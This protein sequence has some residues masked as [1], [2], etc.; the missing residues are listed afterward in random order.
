MGMAKKILTGK[1]WQT[2]FLRNR[3]YFLFVVGLFVILISVKYTTNKELMK[4][5]ALSKEVNDLKEEY[6]QK[7]TYYQNSVSMTAIEQRLESIGVG[8]SK[9]P[10]KDIIIIK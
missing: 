4:I 3:F 5:N 2:V 9:E 6:L 1:I 7:R 8:I 10:V